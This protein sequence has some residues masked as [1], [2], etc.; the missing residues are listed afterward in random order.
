[1][2]VVGAGHHG[3]ST[4][5]AKRHAPGLFRKDYRLAHGLKSG[6]YYGQV[7]SCPRLFFP[8]RHCDDSH[9]YMVLLFF[10]RKSNYENGLIK[11]TI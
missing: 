5:A 2:V 1:M 4:I 9:I 3:Y 11:S 7:I 10:F 6:Y 8:Q